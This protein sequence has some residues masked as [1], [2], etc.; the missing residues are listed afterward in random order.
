MDQTRVDVDALLPVL[1]RRLWQVPALCIT[2][3][4]VRVLGTNV[5]RKVLLPL[6]IGVKRKQ[7]TAPFPN[8][9]LEARSS[10][11]RSDSPSRNKTLSAPTSGRLARRRLLFG[12]DPPWIL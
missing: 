4:P 5:A 6:K 11:Q 2:C 9:P 12:P 8:P 3:E 10:P 7:T 1:E